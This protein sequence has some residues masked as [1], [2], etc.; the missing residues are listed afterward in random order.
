MYIALF[1]TDRRYF[2]VVIYL[3]AHSKSVKKSKT[4][5]IWIASESEKLD[6]AEQYR[7]SI[8]SPDTQG[9]MLSACSKQH[10]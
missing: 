4:E 1:E 3:S 7:F 5:D 2:A 8:K 10:D 9:K 6:L